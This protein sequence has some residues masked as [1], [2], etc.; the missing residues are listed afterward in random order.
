MKTEQTRSRLGRRHSSRRTSEPRRRGFVAG[1]WRPGWG[2]LVWLACALA[3][4]VSCGGSVASV[5]A[6]RPAVDTVEVTGTE[7]LAW[8]QGILPDTVLSDYVFA[9]YVDG[10]REPLGGVRCAPPQRQRIAACTAAFPTLT[11]G[12]HSVQVV[13]I[14]KSQESARGEPLLVHRT[15]SDAAPATGTTGQ[16]DAR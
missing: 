4:L 2:A 7:R 8:N 11:A 16:P 5:S 10:K 13:A 9:V 1:R 14:L 3:P 15:A 12:R 6:R